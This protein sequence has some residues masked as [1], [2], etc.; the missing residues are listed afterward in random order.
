MCGLGCV[1]LVVA[2]RMADSQI[3]LVAVATFAYR[4]YVF[5]RCINQV[6]VL[7]THPARDLAMQ[8]AGDGVVDFLPGM[9]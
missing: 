6:D 7:T 9:G 3:T 1:A 5:Q 2:K 8:L 4:L